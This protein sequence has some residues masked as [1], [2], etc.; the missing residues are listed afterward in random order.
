MFKE[1]KLYFFMLII[2]ASL[3]SSSPVMAGE[4]KVINVLLLGLL[5]ISFIQI[6]IFFVL[7][8]TNIEITKRF[9]YLGLVLLCWPMTLGSMYL[10]DKVFSLS[11]PVMS[12]GIWLLGSFIIPTIYALNL[13]KGSK[14]EK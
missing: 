4:G 14:N 1:N 12:G 13:Y 2:L 10:L 5:F 11:N 9:A 7:K 6:V 8:K 3:T